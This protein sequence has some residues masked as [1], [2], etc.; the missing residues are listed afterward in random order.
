ML[1]LLNEDFMVL[2]LVVLGSFADFI[3]FV[4]LVSAFLFIVIVML[5]LMEVEQFNLYFFQL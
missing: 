3:L 1:L 2:L 4:I 5:M